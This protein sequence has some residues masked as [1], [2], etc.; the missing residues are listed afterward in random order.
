MLKFY[1]HPLLSFLIHLI[2][3]MPK[4]RIYSNW[5][6]DDEVVHREQQHQSVRCKQVLIQFRSFDEHLIDQINVEIDFHSV[7]FV[8]HI[9]IIHVIMVQL[10]HYI[11]YPK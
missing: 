1:L 9:Q 2:Y 5:E 3:Q 6:K 7:E 8:E 4:K 11:K 10:M